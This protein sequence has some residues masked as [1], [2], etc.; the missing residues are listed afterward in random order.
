MRWALVVLPCA[1]SYVSSC[2]LSLSPRTG[3]PCRRAAAPRLDALAAFDEWVRT[4]P[5]ESA[6]TVT[7]VKATCSDLLAQW[8]ERRAARPV[9]SY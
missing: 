1:A 8:R 6:F 5:Y 7:A 2:G 9:V 3:S 4:A